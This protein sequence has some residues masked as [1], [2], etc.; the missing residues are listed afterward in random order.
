MPP[1]QTLYF[2]IYSQP[3]AGVQGTAT[4]VGGTFESY[5]GCGEQFITSK[6]KALSANSIFTTDQELFDDMNGWTD[7]FTFCTDKPTTWSLSL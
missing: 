7:G 3:E 5:T 4:L 2:Y 1:E 6:R